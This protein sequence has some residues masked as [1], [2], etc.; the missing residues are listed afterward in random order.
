MMTDTPSP[1]LISE[2]D[3]ATPLLNDRAALRAKGAAEGYL[4]FRGRLRSE[5]L[6]DLREKILEVVDHHGL[7]QADAELMDGRADL[8]QV[9]RHTPYAGCTEGVFNDVQKLESFHRIAHLPELIEVYQKL[10]DGPVLPHPRNIARVLLPGPQ[11]NATPP[12]QDFVHV[13]GSPET[14]TAWFPLG[15]CPRELGGLSVMPRSHQKGVIAVHDAAGAGG[16]ETALCPNE[17]T[18][19]ETDFRLGDLLTFPSTTVHRGLPNQMGNRIRLSCDLRYQS[20]REPV[21]EKSLLPH[22]QTMTWDEIYAGWERDDLKY[23]WKQAS[24]QIAPWDESVR[25]QRDRICD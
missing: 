2:Y 4:F 11:A 23:Y 9:S 3:D 10:F 18:W 16:L 24:L 7:L 19:L 5:A 8:Q 21:E 14:W 12:H 13:Q 17:N 25:W 1:S 22:R 15:D 6:L 20:T